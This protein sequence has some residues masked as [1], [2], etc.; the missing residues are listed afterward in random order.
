MVGRQM[1]TVSARIRVQVDVH[2][3]NLFQAGL[4]QHL[5]PVRM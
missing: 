1:Q 3:V 2:V 5:Y 4:H